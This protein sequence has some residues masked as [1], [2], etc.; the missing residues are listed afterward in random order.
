MGRPQGRGPRRADVLL[1]G[2]RPRPAASVHLAL[3]TFH[4]TGSAEDAAAAGITAAVGDGT[5]RTRTRTRDDDGEY[6]MEEVFDSS[7]TAEHWSDSEDKRCR[8][9]ELDVEEDELVDP[10]ALQKVKPEE[11]FEGYTGNAGMTLD[12]WYRHAAVFLWPDAQHYHILCDAGSQGAASALLGMVEK[13]ERAES[14]KFARTIIA[15][16]RGRHG[17]AE[18]PCVLFRRLAKL[19]EPGLH[20]RVPAA[21]CC[22]RTPGPTRPAGSP[23]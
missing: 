13:G 17:E 2:A 14:V 5:T 10:D 18:R 23:T 3:L 19:D 16:W 6:E 20:P 22:R 9:G 4:E 7:L 15:T 21:S 11:E 8:L 12:R 1:R